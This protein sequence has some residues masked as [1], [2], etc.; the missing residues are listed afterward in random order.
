MTLT[1]FSDG[2]Q[3]AMVWLRSGDA[4]AP[5][6]TMPSQRIE[7]AIYQMTLEATTRDPYLASCA[8]AGFNAWLA[9]LPC[10]D[11]GDSFANSIPIRWDEQAG[12]WI[13]DDR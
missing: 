12:E 13:D 6:R 8:N 1:V 2:T 11:W 5:V 10:D 7:L 3:S 9:A 4:F